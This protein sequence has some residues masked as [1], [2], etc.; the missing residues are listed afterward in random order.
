MT[1][2]RQE[3]NSR[4]AARLF[5]IAHALEGMDRASAARLGRDGPPDV[6][7]WVQRYNVEGIAGLCNRSAPGRRRKLSEGQMAALK[8]VVLASPNAAVDKIV[9]WRIVDLCRWVKER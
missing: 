1:G 5:A 6:R 9:R 4:L 2:A 7:D 8:A 3:S